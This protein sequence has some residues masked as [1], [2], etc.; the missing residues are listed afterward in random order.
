ME[1]TAAVVRAMEFAGVR[2][3]AV[4]INLKK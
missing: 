3:T 4:N 1:K 2:P